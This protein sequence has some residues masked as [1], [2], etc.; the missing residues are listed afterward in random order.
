MRIDVLVLDDVFDLGLSAVL[1]VFRTAN[2]LIEVG[3]LGV[4]KFEPRIVGLRKTVTTSQ[5]LR[6][7]RRYAIVICFVVAAVLAPPDVV[8]QIALAIP[9]LAFYEISIIVG[10]WIE[11]K[12][13]EEDKKAEEEADT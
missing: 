5:G 8:S 6:E 9:L 7:K 10:S 4:T 11:K 13:A 2:E 12:R 3:G 1:D